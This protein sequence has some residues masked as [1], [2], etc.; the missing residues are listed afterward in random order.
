MIK[1]VLEFLSIDAAIVGLSKL[2]NLPGTKVVAEQPSQPAQ[3]VKPERKPRSDAGKLRGSRKNAADGTSQPPQA[4]AAPAVKTS[5]A[6]TEPAASAIPA[7]P[8]KGLPS[9]EKSPTAAAPK[10]EDAQ[11]ALA[12]VFEAHGLP[13]AQEVLQRFGVTRLRDLLPAQRADFIQF[14]GETAAAKPAAK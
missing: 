9:G 14:A 12:K 7:G 6:A 5:T 3:P 10:E 2:T 11:A 4:E 1:V 13:K 8:D